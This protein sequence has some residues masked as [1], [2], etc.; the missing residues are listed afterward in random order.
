MKN[1]I[2]LSFIIL[3]LLISYLFPIISFGTY[4]KY[5]SLGDSI[6]A[7]YYLEKP[8]ADSYGEKLRQKLYIPSDN[9]ENLSVSAE[10]TLQFYS[11]IQTDE[12]TNAI[13]N[14]DLITIT[15]GSNEILEVVAEGLS[16]ATG[17]PMPTYNMEFLYLVV[18]AFSNADL[19][20]KVEI[21]LALYE[22]V[23]TEDIKGKVETNI[24][25]YEEYW[26]KSLD[27]IKQINPSATI[28][29]TEFFNPYYDITLLNYDFGGWCDEIIQKLNTILYDY[30]ESETEY[31]IAKIYSTFNT[32][33]PRLTN[34]D[35]SL[36][37]LNLDPHPTV[38][39][40]EIISLKILETLSSNNTSSTKKDISTLYI[41]DIE[42]Q[43]YTGTSIEPEIKIKDGNF[44]L[45]ENQDYTVIYTNNVNVGQASAII[46]G[47]GNYTGQT[48][49][50]FNI[51]N[52]N[53]KDISTCQVNALEYQLYLGMNL[54]PDVVVLDGTKVLEKNTDYTLK[55]Q[56]NINVGMATV[57]I[58][59]IGNYTGS[60]TTNFIIAPM[61]ISTTTVHDISDQ[62]YTGKEIT[63][64]II[65]S[66]GAV[67]LIEG[68]DYTLEYENNI[69]KGTATINITGTGNYS[70][71]V[72]K[73]FNIVSTVDS[74]L[75][76][77]SQA[78]LSKISDKTYTGSSITPDITVSING[79][80]L[81]QNID[82]KIF[83]SNNINIGTGI[84]TVVGIGDYTGTIETSFNIVK[85]SI[86][87]LSLDD[88]PNQEYTG[89]SIEP[90]I[91]LTDNSTKLKENVD[92]TVS[93]YNNIEIGLATIQIY[94]KGN[95]A[96]T[97][98]KTFNIVEA[99]PVID[100][101]DEPQDN[102]PNNVQNI[103][104]DTIDKT[105][106]NNILPN[107]GATLKFLI[108]II[109]LIILSISFYKLSKKWY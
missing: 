83:Y 54:E 26:E 19:L 47:T 35:L 50:T 109:F 72:T 81:K 38:L 73:E 77:I 103:P 6:P 25:R 87:N 17:I 45:V 106:S 58:T 69:N 20:E 32:T 68:T 63:P 66:F 59:G 67:K 57:T 94:G 42:N 78:T 1:K 18:D 84:A 40:H 43:E 60:I 76:N 62:L 9:Y 88:I 28:V 55:Y 53:I 48:T 24:Q 37:N 4:N 98:F 44:I 21:L 99:P 80:T 27:Y 36:T 86:E 2:V 105:T 12:Y 39:G 104:G 90:Q 75:Q 79:K 11:T 70:G 85:K 34:V 14:S 97:L 33:N 102:N 31:Q 41:T 61:P 8:E 74:Q 107:A 29:V 91:V 65:I 64:E 93:Y 89:K 15:I 101:E 3:S 52:S 108:A 51:Q 10:T 56:N 23:T 22:Y 95:Y 100:T 16:Y 5:I 7:G 92:Y 30:S 71:T 13:A 82:Y 49:K 46:V 96:G